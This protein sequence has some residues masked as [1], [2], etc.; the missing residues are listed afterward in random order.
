MCIIWK[1]VGGFCAGLFLLIAGSVA[2]RPT[3]QPSRVDPS[4]TGPNTEVPA[5]GPYANG[6]D[7]RGRGLYA[8]NC[9]M[10]H[11]G[12]LEGRCMAPSLLG[13]TDRMTDNAIVD[14]SRKIGQTMCCARHIGK[15]TDA[16][17]ADILAYF[18]AIDAGKARPDNAANRRRGSC[19]G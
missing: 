10:C 11:G 18:R 12:N 19:C 13:I 6:D 1:G 2:A 9:A 16:Q 15:L 14:H 5:S 8:Q 7:R 17:F 3:S 4:T